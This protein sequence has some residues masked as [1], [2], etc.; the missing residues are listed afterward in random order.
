MVTV[1]TVLMA[2][3]VVTSVMIMAMA[4]EGLQFTKEHGP[5]ERFVALSWGLNHRKNVEKYIKKERQDFFWKLVVTRN[6]TFKVF[7]VLFVVH[8]IIQYS[9]V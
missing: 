5:K 6:F 2:F 4:A 8:K 1:I 9:A 7:L 3:I